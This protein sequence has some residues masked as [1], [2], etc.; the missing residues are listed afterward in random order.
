MKRFLPF[1][2]LVLS[3]QLWSL[4]SFAQSEEGNVIDEVIWVV[5][6]QAILR[7]DVENMRLQMQYQK[8]RFSGD[9]DC[10][11]P[12]QL[13]IQKLYLHQAK[14]DSIIITDA[15]ISP[16]VDYEL[17]NYIAQA[18]SRE[19]LETI[20]AKS[21]SAIR[22]ELKQNLK[23]RETV[24]KMK[25]ELV[26]NVKLTLSDVRNF[27][28]QIPQDSLPYIPTT[29]EVQIITMEPEVP[30]A[31]IDE[32]KRKLREYTD[33]VNSGQMSF[34][35]LA[36][37]Y[38]EDPNTSKDG[39]DLDFVGKGSLAPE[40][41]A[42]AFD[43]NVP[44]RV[45]RIVETEYGYHIIQ[46]VEKRGDRIR[47]RHILLKARV[48]EDDLNVA[49][50]RLDTIR[51]SIMEEKFTFEEGTFYSSD[52]DTRNNKGILVNSDLYSYSDRSGTSRFEMSELPQEISKEIASLSVGEISKPF[53][54]INSKN[55]K[56]VAIVKLNN[57]IEGHKAS[58]AE[59]FQSLRAMA[60][61]RKQNEVLNKWLTNK[62]KETYIR[63]NDNYKNC[64]FQLDGWVQN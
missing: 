37:M 56:V 63:I 17:N 26:K 59:D 25:S 64:D 6:D 12:E 49:M 15:Q 35:S 28:D 30:L 51:N 34:S 27:Y 32:I 22:E 4:N 38:S 53:V 19:K 52:K 24:K 54:M 42:A 23:E 11:I 14:L 41:A 13:A 48:S 46:L 21:I 3:G 5:G 39:G 61:E 16:Y 50:Q 47:V 58:P 44:N 8:Q 43:L 2:L 20:Y 36:V 33:Q 10:F 60:E 29:V 55:K 1:V 45:S 40:F 9:P 7:S 18:G 31:E 57:R 62:R